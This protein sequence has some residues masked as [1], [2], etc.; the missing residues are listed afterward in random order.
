MIHETERCEFIPGD[1]RSIVAA[2]VSTKVAPALTRPTRFID[3]HFPPMPGDAGCGSIR[4][5]LT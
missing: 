5:N 3:W 1:L 2:G 4:N